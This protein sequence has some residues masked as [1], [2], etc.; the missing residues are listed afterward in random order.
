MRTRRQTRLLEESGGV[1]EQNNAIESSADGEENQP[2]DSSHDGPPRRK[3]RAPGRPSQPHKVKA[4]K[5][6]KGKLSGVLSLPV[7]VFMEIMQYL[8]LPDVLSLSR[9]NKFFRQMLMT[10]SAA[11]LDVW[12][13]AVENVPGLPPCPKD[14]CEPQY[15]ALIYSKHCSMCGASVVRPMDPYLNVR[16]CKDCTEIHVTHVDETG[17]LDLQ[18]LVFQSSVTR[19]KASRYGMKTCLIRDVE[20]VRGWIDGHSPIPEE[21]L[22]SK[23]DTRVGAILDRVEY[24]MTMEGFL[25]DM[26]ETR[27]REIDE[28][29]EQ[30]RRDVKRRLEEAGWEEPDWTF[31]EFVAR[32][33]ASLVEAP[34][35]LTERAWE[36]LYQSLVPYLE[37]NRRSHTER[38]RVVRK[39]K[40]LR[41]MR[42]LLLAIRNKSN[43]LEIDRKDEENGTSNASTGATT[44]NNTTA[45]SSSTSDEEADSAVEDDGEYGSGNPDPPTPTTSPFSVRMPFPPM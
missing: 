11:T 41:R 6:V 2:L 19:M 30:R 13:T 44:A 21:E 16:L 5:K 7:E 9:S 35:A 18:A 36:K 33:W 1:G 12:R 25:R 17:D 40:R 42:R 24:A 34:Q 43:F 10:R 3:K 37:T 38:S 26:A 29:K 20:E 45:N 39:G 28:L 22:E 15:A 14:L 27:T 31:P 8:T 23:V 4:P 32:K